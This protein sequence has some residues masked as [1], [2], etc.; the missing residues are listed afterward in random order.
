MAPRRLITASPAA[1]AA[2]V[3]HICLAVISQSGP[4]LH[5]RDRL[6]VA[7]YGQSVTI[8][9]S[10]LGSGGREQARAVS[11]AGATGAVQPAHPVILRL[12]NVISHL[13]LTFP[14]KFA[15]LLKSFFL[16][17]KPAMWMARLLIRAT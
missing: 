11:P 7:A 1:P 4:Q 13:C 9:E 8:M 16:R 6:P 5:D 17:G 14:F 10:A 2:H 3:H 15:W 12:L